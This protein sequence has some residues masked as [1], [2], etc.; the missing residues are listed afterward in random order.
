M[1]DGTLHLLYSDWTTRQ[2]TIEVYDTAGRLLWK[3]SRS[4]LPYEYLKPA[5]VL[6]KLDWTVY[7]R[8][9]QDFSKDLVFPVSNEK[10][11]IKEFWRYD[12]FRRI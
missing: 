9:S 2:E 5:N 7:L 12:I 8:V 11:Q 4:D 1:P 10:K 6:Y 3:G